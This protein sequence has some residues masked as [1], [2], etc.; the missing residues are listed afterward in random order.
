MVTEGKK[1]IWINQSHID[2]WIDQS[3]CLTAHCHLGCPLLHQNM[4]IYILLG[5]GGNCI[6]TIPL[7]NCINNYLLEKGDQPHPQAELGHL[8]WHHF[9]S[10]TQSH[11][12][13]AAKL[14]QIWILIAV[15]S[16]TLVAQPP[17]RRPE[18]YELVHSVPVIFSSWHYQTSLNFL[19][20]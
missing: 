17:E 2:T 10:K 1:Y 9:C 13:S 20:Y 3:I 14:K 16:Q 15:P 8:P 7:C 18:F 6:F 12:G 11:L 5:Q 19:Q 4:V